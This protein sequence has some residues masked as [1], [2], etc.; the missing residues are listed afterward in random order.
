MNIS[1][2]HK[3]GAVVALLALVSVGLSAF[4]FQQS[5]TEQNRS[6]RTEATWDLALQ[7]G[8]LAHAIEHVVVEANS[9]FTSDDKE[10]AKSKLHVLESAIE[11]AKEVSASFLARAGTQLPEARKTQL[12][13]RVKEFFDYQNDTAQLGLTISPKAALVQA[14]DEAT[15]KNRELMIKDIEAFSQSLLEKLAAERAAVTQE[16]QKARVL[17]L[18]LPSL[19]I[20]FAVAIALWI[21]RK[22][23]QQP[24]ARI[25]ASMKALTS[26]QQDVNIPY[27]TQRDEIGEIARA[28]HSFKLAAIENLRL[29]KESA[30]QRR[31]AEDIRDHN[32]AERVDAADKQARVVTCLAV[33]LEKLYAGDFTYRL[34]E[35]FAPEYEK[36]RTDFNKAVDQLQNMLTHI[37]A[38]A[39]T[40]LRKTDDAMNA[41]SHLSQRT[42]QQAAGLEETAAALDEM[43]VTLHKTAESTAHARETVF[44][45][46]THAEDGG[47]I[48]GQALTAMSEIEASSKEIAQIVGVIDEIAFQ[49]SLLA[50]NAGVEA[51]R[52]GEAGRGFAVVA[53]EV[54]ALAQRSADAAKEIKALIAASKGQVD[55]GVE[56]VARTSEALIQIVMQAVETGTLVTDIAARAK[57]Q[58]TGLN[59][60]S[61]AISQ[62][63]ELTQQNAGMAEESTAASQELAEETKD[64]ARLIARFKLTRTTE[65]RPMLLKS[66]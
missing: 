16:R 44:S 61:T 20:F 58:A 11:Q 39:Q 15:V 3:L 57:D 27:V 38:N 46:K 31:L 32:E 1:I 14:N 4:A 2:G 59:H 8:R 53:S 18:A 33:G 65:A 66:A 25:I 7:A 42:E 13:L 10:E 36:L 9:V 41:A 45:A 17:Y 40:I 35:P 22:H 54:R 5:L 34:N 56:L 28:I 55:H 6:T 49:T 30:T 51:A 47:R 64:L 19:A 60:I 52:S 21:L 50:L 62:I 26:A 37:A 48:A 29:E 43:T 63:D 23:I 12:S 24:L